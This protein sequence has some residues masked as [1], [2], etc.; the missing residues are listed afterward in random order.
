MKL[1]SIYIYVYN[2]YKLDTT[3]KCIGTLYGDLKLNKIKT[4]NLSNTKSDNEQNNTKNNSCIITK[5]LIQ[6]A[7]YVDIILCILFKN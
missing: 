4:Y 7:W 3:F 5:Q 6:L 1:L 2:Y